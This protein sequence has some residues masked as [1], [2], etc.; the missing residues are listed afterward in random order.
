MSRNRTISLIAALVVA[1]VALL[2][3]RDY[4]HDAAIG[5][6]TAYHIA[7]A[8]GRPWAVA[9]SADGST[10]AMMH[11]E[12]GPATTEVIEV[13]E[14]ATG[15]EVKTISLPPQSW[16]KRVQWFV[17]RPIR[18]CG[19]QYLVVFG[20]PDTLFVLNAG[21]YEVREAIVV[22]DLRDAKGRR[23][24]DLMLSHNVQLD[25]AQGTLALSVS[26]DLSLSALKL[27]D[28]ETGKEAADLSGIYEGNDQGDGMAISPDGSKVAMVTWESGS[29]AELVDVRARRRMGRINLGERPLVEHMLAFA[30]NDALLVGEP[31]CQP[32][33]GCDQKQLPKGRRLRVYP[34]A[35]GDAR[36]FAWPG[37]EV[38]RSMGASSDG[39]VVF[40]Y[41]GE[42][43]RCG[44]C[45]SGFGELKIDDARFLV[46]DR[47]TGQAVARSPRLKVEDHACPL[48]QIMGSCTAYQQAPELEMSADGRAV[49]A[50][51]PPGSFPAA[52]N[53]TGEVEVFRK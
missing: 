10:L 8:H 5:K 16:D 14:V 18:Y 38:Y 12:M 35:G 13:R 44:R 51:W 40:G 30:G 29:G 52:K 42:E 21:S 28:L 2:L 31:E 20:G 32:N 49:A 45:N 23:F 25:C 17:V 15:R 34:I 48:L 47:T 9:L 6:L 26:D 50:F 19:G 27:I 39:S 33:R 22:S 37:A 46:W 3:L 4:F 11:R 43:R 36:T 41:A 24:G 7:P 1:A 53:S